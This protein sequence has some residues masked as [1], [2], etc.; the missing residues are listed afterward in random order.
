MRIFAGLLL[1][2][3]AISCSGAN[4]DKKDPH[5]EKE[6]LVPIEVEGPSLLIKNAY[7][8]PVGS[9]PIPKG[10]VY[11]ENGVIIKVA[12]GDPPADIKAKRVIDAVGKYVTPGVIDTHSHLGVYASPAVKAHADGNEMVK[13]ETP[14]VRAEDAFWSGDP[15]IWRAIS[16]GI[17]TM[18]VLPGSGNIVGGRS[19]TV[20]MDPK[21][22]AKKMRFP[23]APGG[24][25]MA[26]GENPKRVYGDKGGPMTRMGNA[27]HFRSLFERA[28]D[29]GK[30]LDKWTESRSGDKP[31]RDFQLETINLV[32][33]GKLLAHIHCYRNDDLNTLLDISEEYGFNVRSFH[34]G[35][36]AYKIADRL[37]E[38]NVSVSTW[39]D[40]WGFKMEAYDGIPENAGLLFKS[41]AKPIIHSDSAK[42]IRW[43][44]VEASK[45]QRAAVELGIEVSD[46]ETLRWITQNAAWALGIDKYVGTLEE[47]KMA[48]VVIWDAHPLSSTTRAETVY[49]SGKKIFDRKLGYYPISDFETG[50][51]FYGLA[52]SRKKGNTQIKL[53][54]AKLKTF[55]IPENDKKAIL[56]QNALI[57]MGDGSAQK[58][59]IYISDRKISK[60]ASTI[61]ASP[62]TKVVN[63]KGHTITPGLFLAD[64]F[65]GLT[66]VE[67]SETSVD[68]NSGKDEITPELNAYEAFNSLSTRLAITR[69]EGVL[70]AQ[71]SREVHLFTEEALLLTLP[72]D[73]TL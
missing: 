8:Y 43:L 55:K 1:A 49:V 66:E 60:I 62:S 51:R 32:L 48:D 3:A 28:K 11:A 13:P 12:A 58:S 26:C 20:H 34:H 37:A 71:S 50:Q 6:N 73:R 31:T 7:I 19:F 59:D 65:L 33:R 56:I 63:A 14:E 39:A 47:G 72:T 45:A 16:G 42:D 15:D 46:T 41:G 21:R 69:S 17:T 30:Q 10:Y 25:K 18:Q 9:E 5:L 53:I 24:V 35:L 67:L 61:E 29:Y 54:K 52:Q 40:W 4:S 27:A 22:I 23:N 2:I 64:S 70:T 36:E 44:N 57:W 38:K 68:S